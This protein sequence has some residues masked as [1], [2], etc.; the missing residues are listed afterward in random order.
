MW[1]AGTEKLNVRE[2]HGKYIRWKPFITKV[3]GHFHFSCNHQKTVLNMLKNFVIV[4]NFHPFATTFSWIRIAN[5]SHVFQKYFELLSYFI[6]FQCYSIR[7][8]LQRCFVD[9]VK[10]LRWN[11]LPKQYKLVARIY[12]CIKSFIDIWHD[13]S[14]KQIFLHVTKTNVYGMQRRILHPAKWISMMQRFSEN[15]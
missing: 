5:F 6:K 1:K 8:L 7:Q 4:L 11:F 3:L 2:I 13:T 10:Y 9:H 12:F 14:R 15:S